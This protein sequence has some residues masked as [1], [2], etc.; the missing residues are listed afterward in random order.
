MTAKA[1]TLRLLMPQWQG[2]D[3]DSQYPGQIY[4][5]G[6]R[7]LAWLAPASDAPLVEVPVEPFTGA[8]PP[9]Q[10]GILW[11]DVVLK[12][13]R[14]TKKIIAEHA[15]DR[16]IMFGGDC[17]VSQAP[18]DYL[19]GRYNGNLGILWIDAH[20]DITT[21]ADFDHAHTMVLG[22]LLGGGHPLL[23]QEVENPFEIEQ[24]LIAGVDDVLPHEADTIKKTRLRVV[25]SQDIAASSDVILQ[26]LAEKQFDNLAVH[27][28]LDAL[29]PRYFYSQ[30][31]KNP[32]TEPFD[33]TPGKLTIAQLTRLL[34][35]VASKTNIAGI[36][37]AEHMPWDA[38]NLKNMLA[39]FEFMQ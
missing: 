38:L 10:D 3:N 28:D 5:L 19:N 35:D 23:A 11:Q 1:K 22:N 9:T 17:L 12:Q 26:W 32:H 6:A 25:P 18:F 13:L 29:D 37:F 30:L 39:E 16:I 24:V 15:P 21:P 31:L 34:K 36:S 2:G 4:P 7:L 14:A 20:P 8:T 27:V 33:T